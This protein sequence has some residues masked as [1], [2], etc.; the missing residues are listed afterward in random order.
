VEWVVTA[1]LA[2]VR[3]FPQFILAQIVHRWEPVETDTLAGK[4]VLIVG[5]GDIGRAV[6]RRLEPF[7]VTLIRVA[8]R[9][10]TGCTR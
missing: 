8:R 5:V 6:C 10:R 9:R 1:I 4:R 2:S 3:E 7:G